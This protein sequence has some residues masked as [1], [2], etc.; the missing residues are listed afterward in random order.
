[1]YKK[2]EK[3]NISLFQDVQNNQTLR[4]I[5]A[6][7]PDVIF[8]FVMDQENNYYFS[9]ISDATEKIFELN[10]REVMEDANKLFNLIESKQLNDLWQMIYLSRRYLRDL[11]YSC[12]IITPN[13]KQKYLKIHCIPSSV[14]N[15][16][17]VWNGVISDVTVD[18]Q[19]EIA[20]REN[21]LF[22]KAV[23]SIMSK[24][25][26][27]L[28]FETICNT[29]THEV[30][31]ILECDRV[32]V[33]RFR[34]D[35]GG[36]FITESKRKNLISLID[37]QHLAIWD[38]TYLQDNHG[39][40]YRQGEVTVINNIYQA[41]LSLCHIELYEQ[42]FAKA[43][44]V[45]PI[46]CGNKLWGLLSAYHSQTF[47]WASR[48][49]NLLKKIGSQLGMAI[50]QAELFL[51]VQKKS[52]QLKIAKEEAEIANMT[53]SEF[54]ANI[55]HEIRTPMNAILGFSN[56]LKDLVDDSLAK[57]YL[58]AI[59][60]SGESLLA[61][62]ND[63][64]DLSKIEAGKMLVEYES[65]N[66]R[67]LLEEIVNIFKYQSQQKNIDLILNIKDD[68][69]V[70]IVFEP[71]RLRQILFNLIGNAT[72]FTE[73]GFVRVSAGCHNGERDQIGLKNCGFYI[74]IQDTGIGIPEQD[75]ERIFESFTQQN[76]KINRKYGGTGL[77][78][79]I[80]KKLVTM[81]DGSIEVSSAVGV[82]SIFTVTFPVV[83]CAIAPQ[84][85]TLMFADDN[86]EQFEPLTILV[87][88]DVPSNLD[89]I[90]GFFH[91]TLHE[92][93]F[94]QDGQEAIA[95]ALRYKPDLILLDLKMPILDGKQVVKYLKNNTSTKDI[96]IV[97][98]T[99]SPQTEYIEE[100][101]LLIFDL[102]AKPLSRN[103]LV[104]IFHQVLQKNQSSTTKYF[105]AP[106]S[107]LQGKHHLNSQQKEEII[108]I[109]TKNYLPLWEKAKNT[110]I[111]SYI[112]EFAQSL[113]KQ[114]KKYNYQ[115]LSDYSHSL[116]EQI[117]SFELDLL[118]Q[119]L[120]DFPH[121][122]ESIQKN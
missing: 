25:R 33:Y 34:E 40:R 22:Q 106:Q 53:K 85:P 13:Q 59:C 21:V 4:D 38:D 115:P 26:E 42:F 17:T 62:I 75:M 27:S 111:T 60:S 1:M 69:P 51:E 88:D 24:M 87:A 78:L 45:V 105:I 11:N 71:V 35:W 46:F 114:A 108:S 3:K 54:L 77:G 80:T 32:S 122:I 29:T 23:N 86:L 104:Q 58:N 84:S 91:G 10:P 15:D 112:R 30:R 79:A 101:K 14:E 121:L 43:V 70:G 66:V 94:A 96:P 12:S 82:G 44:C 2:N 98:T 110:K 7:N 103:N 97:I 89:L 61:L 117:N 41:S 56:L 102:V 95:N 37:H 28:N 72:K 57:N 5:T 47:L 68:F 74:S 76:G 73:N 9:F 31:N 90:K 65:L 8:Q 113:S 116:E 92:L 99:A 67:T 100:I 107:P 18:K 118:E 120:E 63:I 55:S 20:L 48:Q 64:L 109:L 16:Y 50:E 49:V 52:L 39:G 6:L 119:T 93:V 19:R 83:S 81:L 36:E